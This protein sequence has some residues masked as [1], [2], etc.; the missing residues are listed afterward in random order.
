MMRQKQPLTQ[1]VPR[2]IVLLIALLGLSQPLPALSRPLMQQTTDKTGWFPFTPKGTDST[3]TVIS[4]ADLLLDSPTDNPAS[5]IDNRGFVTTDANGH[6]IFSKTGKRAKFWGT[7][8]VGGAAFPASPDYPPRTGEPGTVNDAQQVAARLAKLG[9]NA[10]RLH[11][12]DNPDW[13]GT[14]WSSIWQNAADN[15]Q[16]INPV[17]LGRLDY[18]I[19][20]LK[21]RGVYVDLNLHV[22][23]TLRPNDGFT[24]AD[25]VANSESSFGTN[26]TQFDPVSIALQK[27]YAEQLLTHVNPYTKLAYKD[28]PVIFTTETTN[29]DSLFLG[30]IENHLNWAT[31]QTTGMPAFYSQELDG[32]SSLS[33]RRLNR[34]ANPGFESGQAPWFT[35]TGGAAGV[36]FSTP[37]SGVNNTKAFSVQVTKSGAVAWDIQFG[38]GQLALQQGQTY[39]GSF[40]VRA[41]QPTS[42][43]VMAM[44]NAPPWDNLGYVQ[45]VQV[46]TAWQTIPFSFTANQTTFGQARLSFDLGLVSLNTTLLFDNFVF[47]E[48]AAFAGWHGWLAKKYGTTAAL[49][50]AWAP[51]GGTVPETEMLTNG[52]FEN[53][54]TNWWTQAFAPAQA[55]F[56]ADATTASQGT[57]SARINVTQID[58][59]GWHVQILQGSLNLVNGQLYRLAFD[60]KAS[61]AGAIDF[62]AQ[63]NHDP[64][65]G[66][67]TWGNASLT[68]QWQPFELVFRAQ[69]SEANAMIV[70]DLGQQVRTVWLDN[71]SLKP[72]NAKG[73]LPGETL[74]AN[75]IARLN[76]NQW[77]A[78]APQRFRDLM[79]FYAD[80][81]ASYFTG[82]RDYIQKT[83]GSRSLNTGTANYYANLPHLPNMAATDFVDN[84]IYWDHP[85]WPNVPPWSST[86][87]V[88]NNNA[89]VNSPFDG[90]FGKAVGAVK[91]K[92]FTI[93]EFN[94]VTPNRYEVEGPL[95]MATFANLQDWDGVF[96]FDYAG[97]QSSYNA[98][99]EGS[100]FDLTGNPID[101]GL[102]PLASRLFLG[103]QTAPAP[104]ET[105]LRFTKTEG[106]DSMKSGWGGEPA[107]FVQDSKGVQ[108]AAAFGSRLRI[109]DF[110]A[111]APV[112]FN[113]PTPA[114]PVY[115][116]GGGQL[117]WDTTTANQARYLVNAPQL[118][119]VVGFINGATVALNDV[120]VQVTGKPSAALRNADFG[121]VLV[122]SR[123]G[124]PIASA[125][126]LL[127]GV[128]TRFENTGMVWNDSF[129]SVDDQWGSA[130]TL[131][132]PL[133]FTAQLKVANST[134]VEVWALDATGAQHH[135][136]TY[137]AV[138][139][140]TIALNL[141]TSV[142]KTLWYLIRVPNAVTP[143]STP[144]NTPVATAT[145][146][147]TPT[148]TK[149][150]ATPTV[151]PTPTVTKPPTATPTRTP[152]FT[153]TP[154]PTPP[155]IS[156]CVIAVNDAALF[157]G[158]RVVNVRVNLASAAQMQL[159]NDGSFIGATWQAYA[160]LT[161]WTL[162]DIGQRIATLVVYARF[163]DA[164]GGALCNGAAVTDDIIYD[165]LAPKITALAFAAGQLQLAAEDQPG[166]SG[167]T[168]VEVS[169]QADFA[170]AGWQP[171]TEAIAWPE[172][173]SGSVYVRV[174]DGAGNASDPVSTPI[175]TD[176]AIFLPVILR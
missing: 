127:L 66:L 4:A 139:A 24:A 72:Y 164:A 60:A 95:L 12:L 39:E 97:D 126:Q 42:I 30:L 58:S 9:F 147:V 69:Q 160:P 21:Q 43:N 71:I 68:T 106:Q 145:S 154:T 36:V 117:R 162:R 122:Q 20:Q 123:S 155:L 55:S 14:G 136:V 133:K 174:R 94:E 18:L 37:N 75:N 38:Q 137:Q 102:M 22:S 135:Q 85:S 112:A 108:P 143:T 98:E 173:N 141:D 81:E 59:Q 76:R 34:L 113:P 65:T 46:T 103:N 119:G 64:Y 175:N 45:T 87:W 92:P 47:R 176:R 52:S 163:R 10:V 40:M 169:T 157:T 125:T 6:F 83:L 73:L 170:D 93:T 26:I 70:F 138:N 28:D 116:S 67:G 111:A 110:N 61:V 99:M 168:E 19:Y 131:L 5:V 7:N 41:S 1:F 167:V 150:T 146:T 142:D 152:T 84:H 15:A 148:P 91:G 153:P 17:Q 11:H 149:P 56:S 158:N 124:Q 96:M 77:D 23:R 129:T 128:L 57:K 109:A 8:L 104:T 144:T 89:W 44:R 118:Q 50:T 161:V 16:V 107:N 49:A 121:A 166:G 51:T 156:G 134:G 80:T 114:G 31:G 82:M 100:Y 140:Q 32:W 105:L 48:S 29:E 54:L 27:R 35:S 159:S 120:Q 62:G 172:T 2:V 74:E 63:Q 115:T 25:E 132:E 171:F 130:P 151:T 79:Q 86:G 13:P 78:Y 53:D 33:G 101:T 3:N 165:P 90:L 88:I